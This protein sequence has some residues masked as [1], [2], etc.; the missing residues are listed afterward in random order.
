[1]WRRRIVR[2]IILFL[3]SQESFSITFV[4]DAYEHMRDV[5]GRHIHWNATQVAQE[6]SLS[7][8][9]AHI[10]YMAP[11][12]ASFF[13]A[14]YEAGLVEQVLSKEAIISGDRYQNSLAGGEHLINDVLYLGTTLLQTN[15]EKW[16]TIIPTT[17]FWLLESASFALKE[18]HFG[19]LIHEYAFVIRSVPLIQTSFQ[20]WLGDY[21]N[22]LKL[23]G[24][25][26]IPR[27]LLQ[28]NLK[29]DAFA[30]QGLNLLRWLSYVGI[31]SQGIY[32]IGWLQ[33]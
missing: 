2:L 23:W 25:L 21:H 30:H 27:L 11:F 12:Y 5:K 33:S 28:N 26:T 4:C 13:F 14:P 16:L 9:S 3:F 32:A 6:T 22:V 15:Q 7:F 29:K 17:L 24:F 31:L 1:M 20:V 10:T 18:R 19:K 8:L